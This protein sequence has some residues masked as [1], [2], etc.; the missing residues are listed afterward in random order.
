VTE[1]LFG[2]Q[3]W[4]P[5]NDVGLAKGPVLFFKMNNCVCQVSY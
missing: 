1:N 2:K 3:I 5:L 4:V